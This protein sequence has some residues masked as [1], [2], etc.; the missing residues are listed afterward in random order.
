MIILAAGKM[1]DFIY[2]E[3]ILEKRW[4]QQTK[5][6]GA[7]PEKPKESKNTQNS[8]I[9]NLYLFMGFLQTFLMR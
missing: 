7:P 8:K 2:T 3:P 5:N 1:Y 4:D 6:Q 9:V